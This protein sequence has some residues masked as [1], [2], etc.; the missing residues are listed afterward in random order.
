MRGSRERGA[1]SQNG[2]R[3]GERAGS[4]VVGASACDA[5]LLGPDPSIPDTLSFGAL[6]GGQAREDELA[7]A[8]RRSLG[9]RTASS[10]V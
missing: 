5:S 7:H 4:Q 3:P 6:L 8:I 9:L 1:V 10:V 2:L